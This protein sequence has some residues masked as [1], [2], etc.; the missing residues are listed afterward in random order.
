MENGKF[1]FL[2][3]NDLLPGLD[4]IAL[5]KLSEDLQLH[6]EKQQLPF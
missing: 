4:S 2:Y 1:H 6:S 3:H 5:Q